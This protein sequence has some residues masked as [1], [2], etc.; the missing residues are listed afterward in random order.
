[1]KKS[2]KTTAGG[3]VACL[4]LL[5]T[6]LVPYFDGDPET[7]PDIQTLGIAVA[8]IGTFL[9]GLFSRDDNVSSMGG[10]ASKDKKPVKK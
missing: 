1:M 5:F 3:I 9:T 4:G 7:A 10:V 8:A 2:T 6:A